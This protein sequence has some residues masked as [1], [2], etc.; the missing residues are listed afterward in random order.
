MKKLPKP[1]HIY[2]YPNSQ[3]KQILLKLEISEEAFDKAFGVNTCCFD[4]KLNETIIYVC[5]V[6]RALYQLGHK[7]G[8]YHAWD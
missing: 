2:G 3:L 1:K 5:D 7:F 6:E 4:E 8:K